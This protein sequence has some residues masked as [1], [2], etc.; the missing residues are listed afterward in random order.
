MGQQNL[1]LGTDNDIAIEGNNFVI[2]QGI[3]YIAQKV[4]CVLQTIYGEWWINV[5]MG[6]PY[7][8]DIL[9]KNPDFALIKNIFTDAILG[10]PNVAEILSLTLEQL[11][12]RTMQVTFSVRC[13]DDT[14]S[15]GEITI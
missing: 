8:Q 12:G 1:K 14:V 11:A 3:D 7:F 6:I 15:T 5:E 4:K 13:I 9:V 10:V 2:I